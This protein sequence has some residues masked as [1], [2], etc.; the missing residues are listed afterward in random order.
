MRSVSSSTAKCICQ[1]AC[2]SVNLS[3][4]ESVNLSVCLSITNVYCSWPVIRHCLVLKHIFS[5]RDV[6][7]SKQSK[8][9]NTKKY[10][11]VTLDHP[12]NSGGERVCLLFPRALTS[13]NKV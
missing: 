6:P 8:L 12:G 10:V 5:D 2:L 7:K 4:C 3:V 1:S 11:V 9:V 13:S